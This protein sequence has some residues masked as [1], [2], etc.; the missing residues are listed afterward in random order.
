MTMAIFHTRKCPQGGNDYGTHIHE[1]FA[2]FI[3]F[4]SKNLLL[5]MCFCKRFRFPLKEIQSAFSKKPQVL[6][7]VFFWKGIFRQYSLISGKFN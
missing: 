3:N 2:F 1:R 6:T 5:V 7:E 4:F